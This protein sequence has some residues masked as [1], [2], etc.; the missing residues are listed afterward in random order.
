MYPDGRQLLR[1][2]EQNARV[3]H[4]LVLMNKRVS[5]T[6]LALVLLIAVYT[7]LTL[8]VYTKPALG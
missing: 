8:I 4:H 3:T 5:S 6:V 2:P 1:S 7:V